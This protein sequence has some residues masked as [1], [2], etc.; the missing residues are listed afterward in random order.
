MAIGYAMVSDCLSRFSNSPCWDPGLY[1]GPALGFYI[2]VAITILGAITLVGRDVIRI[3][4][5][6]RG[7]GPDSEQ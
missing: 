6:L 2:G 5:K 1:R 7:A 4:G 3:L